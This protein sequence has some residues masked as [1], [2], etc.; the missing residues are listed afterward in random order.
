MN[1]GSRIDLSSLRMRLFAAFALVAIVAAITLTVVIRILIPGVLIDH[2]AAMNRM[3]HPTSLAPRPVGDLDPRRAVDSAL[4]TALPI[5]VL[6]SLLLAGIAGALTSRRLLAPIR[7]V[8]R[9]TRRLAAGEL[10]QRAPVPRSTELAGLATDVNHLGAT[11]EA[12]EQRRTRLIGD[13]MHEL[14][15]PLTVID[16]YA[17]GLLDG[18]IQ[19]REEVFAAVSDE[20]AKLKRLVDDLR[21]LSALEEQPAIKLEANDLADIARS[22]AARL[23]SQFDSKDV[24]LSVEAA[25]PCP[26]RCDRRRVE[27]I[28]TNLLGNALTYTPAGGRVTIRI[29]TMPAARGGSRSGG[30]LAVTDT[31]IGIDRS[32]L[33]HV[34]ERFYRVDNVERPPG[35]SG[36]GL[37]IAQ[38]LAS[39]QHGTLSAESGGPGTGATFTLNLPG[40]NG[41]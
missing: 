26:V 39:L 36:I 41:D 4:N 5:G 15:T 35:G 27:Q 18:L 11:L 22:V 17:E 12:A 24:Q 32:D 29:Q 10:D 20:V 1:G 19:P 21:L 6:A 13:V 2:L 14:R 30:V 8:Q 7:D 38:T 28:I 40:P 23:Q 31:G 33:D 3:A 37:S 25:P 16:G 9:A 34:F